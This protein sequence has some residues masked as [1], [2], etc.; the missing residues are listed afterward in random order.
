MEYTNDMILEDSSHNEL[1]EK[2]EPHIHV[3]EVNSFIDKI[4]L[5]FLLN[6]THYQKYLAKTDPQLYAEKQEFLESCSQYRRPIVDM[7]ARLLDNPNHPHYSR[8]VCDAFD[9][10]AQTLIR[11]LEVKEKSD[12]AQKV[13]Q[14]DDDDNE[15]DTLFPDTMNNPVVSRPKTGTLDSFILRR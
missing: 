8:E 5:E 9:K 11:Y 15:E 12:N 3:C 13:F 6:K 14:L 2:P 4:S 10:Y 7:T 1:P